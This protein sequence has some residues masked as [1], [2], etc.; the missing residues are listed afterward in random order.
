MLMDRMNRFDSV[1][2]QE[3]EDA[4]AFVEEYTEHIKTV[5]EHM[6]ES[7]GV[8]EGLH[9]VVEG[10]SGIYEPEA[11]PVAPLLR[12]D[13]GTTMKQFVYGPTTRAG[14]M[15]Q[16]ANQFQ[17]PNVQPTPNTNT[18]TS[19]LNPFEMGE[20]RAMDVTNDTSLSLFD[21]G[22]DDFLG[23]AQKLLVAAIRETDFGDGVQPKSVYQNL[24]KCKVEV[25]NRDTNMF[26]VLQRI[27]AQ[28]IT[29]SA[30]T[31]PSDDEMGALIGC[32]GTGS[33]EDL[34]EC[35]EPF[36]DAVMNDTAVIDLFTKLMTIEDEDGDETETEDE[37]ASETE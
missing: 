7:R 34:D 22:S 5:Y 25:V 30:G 18:S 27:V 1:D 6:E 15:N 29:L 32:L 11:T 26:E 8:I 21:T 33:M 2:G 31:N 4:K 19:A 23:I 9:A 16:T 10:D 20:Q 17:S 35:K 24:R 36:V 14:S 13:D 12:R 37:D 3:I 28:K